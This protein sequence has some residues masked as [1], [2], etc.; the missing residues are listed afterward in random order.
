MKD[1]LIK[2]LFELSQ[3]SIT[4][5][6]ILLQQNEKLMNIISKLLESLTH[7]LHDN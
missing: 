1:E 4:L 3:I 5:N 2:S 7:I 6:S